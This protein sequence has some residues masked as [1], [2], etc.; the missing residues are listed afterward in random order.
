MS[1][2]SILQ[3]SHA[4]ALDSTFGIGGIV[5]TDLLSPTNLGTV[6]TANSLLIQPDGKLVV[7]GQ[8]DSESSTPSLAVLRYNSNGSLDTTFDIDGVAT[9]D[10]STI[11]SGYDVAYSVVLQTDGKLVVAGDT[12]VPFPSLFFVLARYNTNGSLDNSFSKDGVVVTNTS[13]P[14]E[15]DSHSLDT[16]LLQPNGKLV[17]VGT[18]NLADFGNQFSS[19]GLV[20]YNANGSLDTRF[21]T[22]GIVTNDTVSGYVRY[23]V[24]GA[25]LQPDGKIVVGAD[26]QLGTLDDEGSRDFLAARYS[27][28]GSLDTG[29]GNGGSAIANFT[30]AGLSNSSVNSVV[31][32][33]DG[34]ILL[35]GQATDRTG[36]SGAVDFAIARYNANGTLDTSFGTNGK[37]LTDFSNGFDIAKSAVL[38]P[39]GKLLVVGNTAVDPFFDQFD[40]SDI[41]VV[42]YNLDGSLDTTFG[43]GGKTIIDITNYL[44]FGNSIALQ[45]DGKIVLAGSVDY[46]IQGASTSADI[47]VVRLNV[48]APLGSGATLR[49][50]GSNNVLTGTV[51]N[52][53]FTGN[54]GKDTFKLLGST[55]VITDFGGVGRGTNAAANTLANAD[56]LQ[57]SG[58]GLTAKKML[59]NQVGNNTEITFVG[60]NDTKVI[61]QNFTLE[62]LDNHRASNGASTDV[63]NILFTGETTPPTFDAFDVW[64]ANYTRYTQVFRQNTVTFLNDLNNTVSGFNSSVDVINGQGGNDLLQGLSGNDTLRGGLGNDTLLGGVG[65]D[66]LVG[67]GGNDI[68]QGDSGNDILNG[69]VGVDSFVFNSNAVFRSADLG[70]D[71]IEDFSVLGDK[72]VLDQTTFS[73]LTSTA[74]EGF[75]KA[76]EF[77]TVTSDSAAATSGAFIVYNSTNGRLFYNQNGSSSGFGSGAQFAALS[78]N[79]VLLATDFVIRA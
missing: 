38:Q 61:L 3:T 53:T 33:D 2:A 66:V 55:D 5:L 72:L 31:R 69:G 44:D 60:I 75:S 42:R 45:A 15:L 43:N 58:T 39:D 19:I 36:V 8:T 77:A 25:V 10:I 1:Q 56:T 22:D 27:R 16:L 50:N 9:T 13:P 26:A 52:D 6:D 74:G 46:F 57:F 76:S 32:Q 37:V 70:V 11:Y 64:N 24:G 35:V 78:G 51:G 49:G 41:V 34:K 20:R 17:A 54:G 62:R 29:F 63:T 71:T 21:S 59:L 7:V 79:P 67:N 40:Q 12:F 30:G 47:A 48:D 28:D 14:S 73:K 68:L 65:F 23:S 18:T 4:G